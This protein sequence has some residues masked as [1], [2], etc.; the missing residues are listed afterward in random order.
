M[1]ATEFSKLAYF[2]IL[3]LAVLASKAN[4]TKMWTLVLKYKLSVVGRILSKL[5]PLTI[6]IPIC[7]EMK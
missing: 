3:L 1:S 6:Q 7:E 4:K 5:P 2:A